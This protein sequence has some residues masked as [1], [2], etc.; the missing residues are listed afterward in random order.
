[1]KKV[2]RSQG[3]IYVD[4]HNTSQSAKVRSLK[5]QQQQPDPKA[6]E[7]GPDYDFNNSGSAAHFLS[8]PLMK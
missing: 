6:L 2:G 4:E 8:S 3:D 7:E 1:M 5:E